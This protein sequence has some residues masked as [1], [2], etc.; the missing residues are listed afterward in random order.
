MRA[1]GTLGS[2]RRYYLARYRHLKSI[3]DDRWRE[4]EGKHLETPGTP[5]ATDFPHRASLVAIGYVA[6]EDF[7][8]ATVDELLEAGLTLA[9]SRAAI[10]A[11]AA[12]R[13]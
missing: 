3:R 11:A 6:L 13:I 7:E 5:L 12:A 2:S 10:A 8:G 9:A 4:W 1:F